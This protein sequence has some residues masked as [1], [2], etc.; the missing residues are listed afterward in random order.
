MPAASPPSPTSWELRD[1]GTKSGPCRFGED[2][3][4]SVLDLNCKAHD[5]DNLYVVD[6]SF[7]VSSAAVNPTLTI[8][9]NAIR[10]AEHLKSRMGWRSAGTRRSRDG[11]AADEDRFRWR[12][13]SRMRRWRASVAANSVRSWWLVAVLFGTGWFS[14][15]SHATEVRVRE[16][17]AIAVSVGD[18]DRMTKFYTDVLGFRVDPGEA[19]DKP[20]VR[21]VA[22][23]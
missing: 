14:E 16:V 2:P 12:G 20:W 19:A 13:G 22:S 21:T 7:F 5:L 4:T 6:G 23:G 9:A 8:I 3:V 1:W 10:V 18:L 15:V 11:G 17:R